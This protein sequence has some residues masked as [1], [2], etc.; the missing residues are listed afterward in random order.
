MRQLITALPTRTDYGVA[1]TGVG[2]ININ[3]GTVFAGITDDEGDSVSRGNAIDVLAAP[4]PI[5][6]NLDGEV[7]IFGNILLSR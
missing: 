5:D 7:D 6:I 4:N 1:S 3:N 2:T